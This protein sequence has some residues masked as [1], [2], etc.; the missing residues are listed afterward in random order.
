MKRSLAIGVAQV[1][2]LV[3]GTSR[4]GITI[5]AGLATGLSRDVAT[6][7][8]F[9]LGIPTIAAAGALKLF[10]VYRGDAILDLL[11]ALV[12][13]IAAFITAFLT[14]KF[15]LAFLKS[16]SFA[17]LAIVRVLLGILILVI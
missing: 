1:V 13:A 15:L 8:S 11:P 9:L 7:F 6:R 4:S 16:H 12:G 10:Q 14:I 2:A 5:T 17:E 3:P